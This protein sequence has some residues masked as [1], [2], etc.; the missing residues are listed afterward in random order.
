[1]QHSVLDVRMLDDKVVFLFVQQST[2]L[3]WGE[4]GSQIPQSYTWANFPPKV[5]DKINFIVP[6]EI[7]VGHI[8]YVICC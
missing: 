5:W 7:C 2:Y 1:M 4:G 3:M 6:K 8:Q